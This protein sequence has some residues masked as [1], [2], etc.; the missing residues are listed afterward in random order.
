M[1]PRRVLTLLLL[2]LIHQSRSLETT[3]TRS[4]S[5]SRTTG[6][7]PSSRAVAPSSP[8]PLLQPVLEDLRYQAPRVLP[9]TTQAPPAQTPLEKLAEDIRRSEETVE[10]AWRW[11]VS[12]LRQ[13]VTST[14]P[15]LLLHLEDLSG[16]AKTSCR[17]KI[18]H[19]QLAERHKARHHYGQEI[20]DLDQKLEKVISTLEVLIR[21][22]GVREQLS[23]LRLKRSTSQEELDQVLAD[24]LNHLRPSAR[25]I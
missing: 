13:I 14:V 6:S 3:T 16:L 23:K 5:S 10:D 21:S 9:T 8:R 11:T 4:H 24:V 19:Q 2:A 22:P 15:Q 12:G 25:S 17:V 1:D 7:P 20:R 18:R